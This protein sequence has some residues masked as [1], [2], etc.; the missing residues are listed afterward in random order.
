M[1]NNRI[2]R[3]FEDNS[4]NKDHE[5]MLDYFLGWTLRCAQSSNDSEKLK[6]ASIKI[7]SYLL[8]EKQEEFQV[9]SVITW[10]KW[11]Q[12]DLCAE[13]KLKKTGITEKYALLFEN[14]MYTHLRDGQLEKYF[15]IFENFYKEKKNNKTD[16]ERKYIFLTC[17]HNES[18]YKLDFEECKKHGFEHHFFGWLKTN[19]KI[20]ETGNYLFD[21]FWFRYW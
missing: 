21:E 6:E 18:D 5:I 20:S 3:F 11:N 2:P 17:C 16:Y 15:N 7:L 12:I 8:F 13:V 14:K 4:E 19:S 10:K 1:K 9:E